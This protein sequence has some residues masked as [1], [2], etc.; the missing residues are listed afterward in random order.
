MCQCIT[1]NYVYHMINYTMIMCISCLY[2]VTMY[3]KCFCDELVI[4]T[5][6]NE[7]SLNH[8]LKF[9][10]ISLGQTTWSVSRIGFARQK[11]HTYV[12]IFSFTLC[13]QYVLNYC[14]KIQYCL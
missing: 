4:R 7:S 12:D 8:L 9:S 2:H 11:N 1:C 5:S 10:A 3:N 6:H 14:T 13:I